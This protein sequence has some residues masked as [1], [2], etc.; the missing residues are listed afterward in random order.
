MQAFLSAGVSLI[1][2]RA[3]TWDSGSF[4]DLA[5]AAV[6][7]AITAGAA[8]VINDRADIAALSGALGLHVGQDDLT[9][10][11]ARKVVGS[12]LWL[13]LSTHTEPQW[14]AALDAPIDYVAIGPV[15]GTETKATGYRAVGLETVGRVAACAQAMPVVAIGGIT[16]DNAPA[17]IAAGAS[18][19]AVISDLLTGSPEVRARAFI[20]ALA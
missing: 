1:Q 14:T 17:V 4:L 20:Q 2:L 5:N 7:E 11:D 15:Y 19:V 8:I 6:T 13:G 18:A 12:A 3:K 10:T 16:L 9:P